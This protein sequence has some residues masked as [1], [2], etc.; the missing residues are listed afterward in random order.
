MPRKLY[1]CEVCKT[2]FV[3]E[4]DAIKC[5]KSHNH[6]VEIVK[7]VIKKADNNGKYPARIIVKMSDGANIEYKR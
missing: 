1:E 6:C 3:T 5:E 7:E 2:T 4:S